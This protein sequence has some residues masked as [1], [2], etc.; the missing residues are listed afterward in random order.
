[1]QTNLR[2][3][4]VDEADNLAVKTMELKKQVI[5]QGSLLREIRNSRY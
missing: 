5:L 1:M 2:E 4:T 3:Y